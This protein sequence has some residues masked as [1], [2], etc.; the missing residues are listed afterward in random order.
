MKPA[1][2]TVG[3]DVQN[4]NWSAVF[5]LAFSRSLNFEAGDALKR[6]NL[7]AALKTSGKVTNNATA[8]R[9]IQEA[10][11]NDK[12]RET[13]DGYKIVRKG[14]S[15][16]DIRQSL[17]TRL[18]TMMQNGK[19]GVIKSPTSSGKTHTP[20][21]TRWRSHPKITEE[22]PVV[23]LSGTTDARDD[24]IAKS[25]D[26]H[27][28]AKVLY[29]RKDACPL[30]RGDYDSDNKEGNTPITSPDGTEPSEWFKTMCEKRGLHISVVHGEFE[31][32]YR[33]TLP[34]CENGKDC[35]STTQWTDVPR[36]GDGE[37]EYDVLHATHQ[38][39]RVPQLIEDCNLIIDERPDFT[40]DIAPGRLH[41]MVSSYLDEIDAPIK[42][43]ED[44]MAGITGNFDVDFEPLRNA[45]KEPDTGWFMTDSNAHALAPGIVKTILTAEKRPHDRWVGTTEYTYPTLNPHFDGPDQQV[46]IRVVFNDQ[47]DIRLLQA[48]PDFSEARCVIGL[49]AY[50]TLPKWKANTVWDVEIENIVDTDNLHNWRRNQRNLTIVQVGD[51]KYS[52]TRE[53]YN[54]SKVSVLCNTLRREYGA[55]FTTGITSKR[56]VDDLAE[57]LSEAGINIPETIYF[58]NEKSVEH[59]DSEQ[60]GVVAG[61][62]SPSDEDIRD[63]IALLDKKAFPRRDEDD[64]YQGQQWVGEDANIAMELIAD[65][66]EKRVLQA[67]GRYARSPQQPDNGA[68]VFVMTNVLPDKYIDKKIDNVSV[69]RT[70][71]KEILD[72][73]SSSNGVAP[74]TI[75][76]NTTSSR[77]HVYDTLKKCRDYS[78]MQVKEQPGH[79]DPD[80][81]HA[82]YSPDGYIEV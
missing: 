44:L 76:E 69:F 74:R 14:P 36:N 30:A 73:V 21:T 11:K 62:I 63:W 25:K 7:V 6:G 80:I 31:R 64:N 16:G 28:T 79:N 42:T 34:C 37:I 65:V 78:W 55:G 23:F 60:A 51:N 68:T 26:S 35:P 52:W 49:D 66:R 39:A 8:G 48:I 13:E 12:L 32:K 71:E 19:N 1:I 3:S 20:S 72:Y 67:C 18:R 24:A 53:G 22:Q 46:T 9:V 45:L 47:N 50:P 5:N 61:C 4:I 54:H 81:F 10:V 57:Q 70:K 27:A 40:Q 41:Q 2:K 15:T 33:H 56:F 29:G 43:W 82:D 77:R 17:K 58:G 38:F 75:E 59:F